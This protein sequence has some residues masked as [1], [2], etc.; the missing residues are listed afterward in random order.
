M[1]T[2]RTTSLQTASNDGHSVI[3]VVNRHLRS[4]WRLLVGALLLVPAS[5][6]LQS[7]TLTFEGLDDRSPVADFYSTLGARFK[8]ATAMVAS[9]V[10]GTGDFSGAPSMPTAA[11]SVSGIVINVPAGMTG[12]LSFYYSNPGGTTNVRLFT[13]LDLRDGLLV[14]SLQPTTPSFHTFAFAS[15]PFDGTALSVA[16]FSR[17]PGG[18][19][20]DNLTIT[21]VPVTYPPDTF[22]SDLPWTSMRNGW[23]PVE[24]DMSN[25]ETNEIDGQT[26]TINGRRYDKGLGVHAESDVRYYLGGN[27]STFTAD[28]GVDDE[29][30]GVGSVVFQ[31]W[32]DGD[33][34]YDSGVMTGNGP[35]RTINVNVTGRHELALIV[36]DAGDGID[37]DHAD[38]ADARIIRTPP[39]V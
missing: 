30:L 36:T 5:C 31:V 13:A 38:W 35:T 26:I 7:Q 34:L 16:I 12:S 25:G 33:L 28:L 27:Y 8:G 32:A 39:I 15:I 17:G 37:S 6:L 22:L 11:F 19:F 2:S 9:E 24:K 3:R 29:T 18:F 20:I 14:D 4:L 23:G 10:G 21:T 1:K